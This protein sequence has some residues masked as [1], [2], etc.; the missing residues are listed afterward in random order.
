MAMTNGIHEDLVDGESV[1]EIMAHKN[2]ITFKL[3]GFKISI[4]NF[5]GKEDI[6]YYFPEYFLTL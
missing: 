4:F 5:F 6:F 1:H 2:G 3:V